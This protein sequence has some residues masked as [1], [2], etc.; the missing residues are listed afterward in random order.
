MFV[1]DNNLMAIQYFVRK[2]QLAAAH[3]EH[4]L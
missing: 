3:T 1:G 4:I 2:I